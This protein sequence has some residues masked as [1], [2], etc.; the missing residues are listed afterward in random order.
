MQGDLCVGPLC[1]QVGT[2]APCCIFWMLPSSSP[3]ANSWETY[4]SNSKSVEALDLVLVALQK[5]KQLHL[6]GGYSRS[7]KYSLLL[8][9]RCANHAEDLGV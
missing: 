6:A 4:R 1:R 7:L 9:L 5:K 2:C 3:C 8:C